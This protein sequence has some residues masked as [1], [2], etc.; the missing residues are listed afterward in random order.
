[1]KPCIFV[2]ALV[3]LSGLAMAGGCDPSDKTCFLCGGVNGTPC[4]TDCQSGPVRPGL[5]QVACECPQGKACTCYCPL[6]PYSP[7]TEDKCTGVVC[8]NRC[9]QGAFYIGSCNPADGKCRYIQQEVCQHGCDAAGL[10]CVQVYSVNDEICDYVKGENCVD[11]KQDCACGADEVCRPG[12]PDAGE[13]GCVP[14]NPEQGGGC[15][16]SAAVLALFALLAAFRKG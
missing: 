7:Q 13:A 8:A 10:R 11:S 14:L 1:M 12:D 3:F 16:P 6:Q 2:V 9:Q 15:A 5:G 4:S